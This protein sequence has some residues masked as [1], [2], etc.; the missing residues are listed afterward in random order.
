MRNNR[1]PED[2]ENPDWTAA[3]GAILRWLI[4]LLAAHLGG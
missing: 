3:L 1:W 2:N 4:V